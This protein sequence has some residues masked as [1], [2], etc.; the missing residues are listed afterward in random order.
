MNVTVKSSVK[1]LTT[2][3]AGRRRP[4]PHARPAAV[5][6]AAEAEA[7]D[8]GRRA[9]RRR[10][11]GCAARAARS[12]CVAAPRLRAAALLQPKRHTTTGS[13]CPCRMGAPPPDPALSLHSTAL[14]D[15]HVDAWQRRAARHV[16]GVSHI[17]TIDFTVTFTL[18]HTGWGCYVTNPGLLG[19]ALVT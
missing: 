18:P 17:F 4:A 15:L 3:V 11:V 14:S 5:A 9:S 16:A 12:R 19:W 10:P 6:V 2:H 1:L 13:P 8:R 7:G